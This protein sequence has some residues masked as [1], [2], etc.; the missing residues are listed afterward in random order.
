M[1]WY[2]QNLSARDQEILNHLDFQPVSPRP[3]GR[4]PAQTTN[5]SLEPIDP[6]SIM[7]G[8]SSPIRT[9][10]RCRGSSPP[11]LSDGKLPIRRQDIQ[12]FRDYWVRNTYKN[13][14]NPKVLRRDL[15]VWEWLDAGEGR[16]AAL[17]M[18]RTFKLCVRTTFA[19]AAIEC[20]LY[21]SILKIVQTWPSADYL[22]HGIQILNGRH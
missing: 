18:Y 3:F 8:T 7:P 5:P 17:V 11:G 2:V 14:I 16:L 15:T 21:F 10:S 1:S 20:V 4:T 19:G 22:F 6:P 9:N 12:V 13:I